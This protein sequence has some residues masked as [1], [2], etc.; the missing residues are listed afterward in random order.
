MCDESCPLPVFLFNPALYEVGEDGGVVTSEARPCTSRVNDIQ[1][2]NTDVDFEAVQRRLDRWTVENGFRVMSGTRAV[3]DGANGELFTIDMILHKVKDNQWPV[4]R[5]F[6]KTFIAQD[7]VLAC[8][9]FPASKFT[10]SKFTASKF[11]ASKKRT[12]QKRTLQHARR[13]MQMVKT[14][15]HKAY[16]FRPQF[17]LFRLTANSSLRVETVE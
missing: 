9:L 17:L 10:A 4:K 1:L 12:L 16:N 2:I 3:Q 14:I 6:K 8:V 13:H 7:T 11:T 5:H 15:C